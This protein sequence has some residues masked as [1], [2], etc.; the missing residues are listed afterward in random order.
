MK[1]NDL[2]GI[3]LAEYREQ[4]MRD[5]MV[6][7]HCKACD[8]PAKVYHNKF[9]SAMARNAIW[10][11][12]HFKKHPDDWLEV[13]KYLV[14]NHNRYDGVHSKLCVYELMEKNKTEEPTTGAKYSGLYR[15]TEKGI[16]FVEERFRVP[17]YWTQYNGKVLHFDGDTIGIRE[18]LGKHFNYAELMAEV[19][20]W[21]QGE[22]I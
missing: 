7:T 5:A 14:E 11:Y 19:G 13:G 9:N 3:T 1:Q 15:M 17:E 22:F 20:Y 6:G 16:A 10:L 18:A 8:Q 12:P 2:F 4:L 21:K